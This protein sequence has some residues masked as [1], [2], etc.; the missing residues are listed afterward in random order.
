VAGLITAAAPQGDR[1]QQLVI[2]QRAY[3]RIEVER[4]IV[5]VALARFHPSSASVLP[6]LEVRDFSV[7]GLVIPL[8]SDRPRW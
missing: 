4:L 5:V 3:L 2:D 1:Q 8:S 7:T 6:V